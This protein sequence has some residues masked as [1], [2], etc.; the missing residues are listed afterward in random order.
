MHEYRGVYLVIASAISFGFMPIFAKL[1]YSNDVPILTLLLFRFLIASAIVYIALRLSKMLIVPRARDLVRLFALG[2][3]GYFAQS[4]FYF[5]A[6]LYAPVSIVALLLYTYPVFVSIITHATGKE[7]FTKRIGIAITISIIGL[8]LVLNPTGVE[9]NLGSLLA[10]AASL[11]Y[12][13]YII[14]SSNL[15]ERV[16]G[17]VASFYVMISAAL[18][19]FLASVFANSIIF[20]FKLM[21]MIWVLLIAMVS[22]AFAISSFFIG[23]S[24]IGPSRAALLSLIEPLTSV[25]LSYLIFS[26][27]LTPIQLLGGTLILISSAVVAVRR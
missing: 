17:E 5:L 23:L 1:A 21:G 27:V 16:G 6:L 3:V 22:T 10:V 12:T 18:S 24:V 9:L 26:E 13:A 8:F 7:R 2:S 14:I 25:I 15:L 4:S 20:Q 19:F 11:T